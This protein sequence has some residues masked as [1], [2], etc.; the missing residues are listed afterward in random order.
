MPELRPPFPDLRDA[1]LPGPPS[2]G[3]PRPGGEG[4][5]APLSP[6]Q[7]RLLT[8]LL[9]EPPPV[10]DGGLPD[11][12]VALRPRGSR[13]PLFGIGVFHFRRLALALG[14]DQ[15]MFGLLG[16]DLDDDGQYLE[17]V[18]ELAAQYVRHIRA[19]R[20]HGPYHL[21]GFCFGGLVAY[22]VA[23][24]LEAERATVGRVMLLAAARPA[25][26]P[27]AEPPAPVSGPGRLRALARR[28]HAGDGALRQWLAERAQYQATSARVGAQR[29]LLAT[30]TRVGRT[31]PLWLRDA[32]TAWSHPDREARYAPAPY[33]GGVT[34][35]GHEGD[36]DE[37][38]RVLVEGW[39]P[40]VG[41]AEAFD[42]PAG[43]H[44]D[45]LKEPYVQA[46]AARVQARLD[47][48]PGAS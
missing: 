26:G 13:P 40:L 36:P 2:D 24:Q 27:P 18:E 37:S 17:R 25:A 47:T 22:E 34:V 42:V 5:G 41:R 39:R 9:A 19:V 43:R 28:V 46:L 4:D 23:R 11:A 45:S 6:E 32:A 48:W 3:R 14:P 44:M 16:L 8:L 38:A 12:V 10:G 33:G 15:P 1:R 29:L 30:C 21:I 7:E 31:P 20:P 35:I